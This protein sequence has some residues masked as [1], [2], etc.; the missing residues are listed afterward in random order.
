MDLPPGLRLSFEDQPSWEDREFVDDRLGQYNA[1]FLRDPSWAYFGIFVRDDAGAIRAGLIGNAYAGW[2]FVALLWVHADLRRRGIGGGLLAEA[3]RRGLACGCHSVWLDTFSF[4]AP[5]FY[6]R[7][8]YEVFATLDYPPDHRR[9]F[10]KKA[11][12]TETR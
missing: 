7:L 1:P 8:G 12:Q 3:E 10:L 6:Q 9:Y 11:L 2:L 4:Q 5:D